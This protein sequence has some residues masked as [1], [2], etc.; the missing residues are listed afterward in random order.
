MKWFNIMGLIGLIMSIIFWINHSF[1]DY[2]A[3]ILIYN[4]FIP[5][6]WDVLFLIV[7]LFM[8][9]I[10][11]GAMIENGIKLKHKGG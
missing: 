9:L 11:I 3:G 2:S 1:T 6:G 4:G 10:Y 5:E 8:F 7:P